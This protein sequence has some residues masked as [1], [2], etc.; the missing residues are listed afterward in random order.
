MLGADSTKEMVPSVFRHPSAFSA[1]IQNTVSTNHATIKESL[2]IEGCKGKTITF[3]EQCF[4]S[5]SLKISIE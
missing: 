4:E 5:Q 1:A 3:Q 2:E